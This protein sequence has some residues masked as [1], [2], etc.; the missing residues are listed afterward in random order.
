MAHSFKVHLLASRPNEILALE[1]TVLE[2]TPNG[3]ENVVVITNV[4]SNYNLAI[5]TRDQRAI[6]VTQLVVEWF[7]KFGVPSCLHSDEGC[8]FES[9]LIRELCCMMWPSPE[10]LLTIQLG[11]VSA[12]SSIG[13]CII[14]CLHFQ[15]LGRGIGLRAFPRWCFDIR[16]PHIIPQVNHCIF[17]CLVKILSY[18]GLVS[19]WILEH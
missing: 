2:P 9:A 15:S 11:M 10:L 19:D 8:N 13:H 3:I 5:T 17:L 1:F 18:L 16:L 7:Y 12:S 14:S 6:T 4:F